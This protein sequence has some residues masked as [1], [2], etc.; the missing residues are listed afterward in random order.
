M[1]TATLTDKKT[2]TSALYALV[3]LV[4]GY[5][6]WEQVQGLDNETKLE[7]LQKLTLQTMQDLNN[8]PAGLDAKVLGQVTRKLRAYQNLNTLQQVLLNEVDWDN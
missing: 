6:Q 4:A 8:N 1:T 2:A 5:D 3:R 7:G